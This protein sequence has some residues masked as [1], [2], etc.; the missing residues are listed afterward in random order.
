MAR[1]REIMT[2]WI[3]QALQQMDGRERSWRF[4]AGY[5][6]GM[7]QKSVLP[8]IYCLNGNTNFVGP[9]TYYAETVYYVPPKTCREESGSWPEGTRPS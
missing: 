4:L 6:N 5:G 2:D 9:A 3:V 7:S 1:G 8:A